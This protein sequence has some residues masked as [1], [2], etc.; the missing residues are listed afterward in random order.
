MQR[1]EA[2]TKAKC[3]FY[4][5]VIFISSCV[6]TLN[7]RFAFPSYTHRSDVNFLD[8]E[9]FFHLTVAVGKAAAKE[10]AKSK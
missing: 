10:E 8:F 9:R 2:V 1:G 5:I 4:F 3:N 7:P 6:K